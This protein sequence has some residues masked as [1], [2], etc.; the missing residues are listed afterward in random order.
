MEIEIEVEGE[1]EFEI[2]EEVDLNVYLC[3]VF[4]FHPMGH[5]ENQYVQEKFDQLFWARPVELHMWILCT[6]IG[7]PLFFRDWPWAPG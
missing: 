3:H 6:G 7:I 5:I 4:A 1:I 2:G